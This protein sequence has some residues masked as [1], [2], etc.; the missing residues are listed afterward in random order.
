MENKINSAFRQLSR[1][2]KCEFI[3]TQIEYASPRAVAQY[4]EDYFLDVF[5]HIDT[6]Q[7]AEYLK[8]QG[9]IV[10]PKTNN[11]NGTMD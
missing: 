5:K 2:A 3:S 8:L 1:T 10:T 4:A 9:Y 11:N 6:E 7:I